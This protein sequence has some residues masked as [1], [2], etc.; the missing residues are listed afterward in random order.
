MV[1]KASE[2][3]PHVRFVESDFFAL[4]HESSSI[5]GILAFYCIVH[6]RPDQLVPAFSEMFRVLGGA[7]VL[8]LGFHAGTEVIRAENF[9]DTG[10]ALDFQFFEPSAVAAAL[11]NVGFDP[12]EV[13]IREP[14]ATEYSSRRCYVF[15]HKPRNMAS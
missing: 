5:A 2:S 8:L 6:L 11:T 10:T 15:A 9:L 3:F 7:G 4:P 12:I 1:A 13:R 14:Y